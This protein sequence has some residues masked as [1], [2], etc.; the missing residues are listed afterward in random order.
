MD[1]VNRLNLTE[2]AFADAETQNSDVMFCEVFLQVK[3]EI[4]LVGVKGTAI[5]SLIQIR[6]IQIYANTYTSYIL[7]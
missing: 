1:C 2:Q 3:L 6:S 7:N 4:I 5:F